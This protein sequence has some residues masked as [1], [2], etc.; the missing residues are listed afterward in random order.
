MCCR[1]ANRACTDDRN[2]IW[3]FFNVS[4]TYVNGMPRLRTVPFREK[5]LQSADGDCLIDFSAAAGG[6]ARMSTDSTADAGKRIRL[7]R[8][9]IGFFKSSFCYQA[10][11]SAG[12]GMCRASHHAGKV[13][14]QPILVDFFC[15]EPIQHLLSNVIPVEDNKAKASRS[16]P[17]MFV[18]LDSV[19]S[20]PVAPATFTGFD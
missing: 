4:R 10:D 14:V 17:P 9:T 19:K 20:A 13:C 3:E 16:P 2:L 5:P 18:Y 1:Q 11:V 7:A 6:F 15:S 12:I 8:E